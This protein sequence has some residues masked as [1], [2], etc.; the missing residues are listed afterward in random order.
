MK[1]L[2]IL[3]CSQR[4]RSEPGLLPAIERY[5]GP[6]FGVARKFLHE[7]PDGALSIYILS[8]QFGLI[9]AE[10][11]IPNYN[12]KMTSKRAGELHFQVLEKFNDALQNNA[13]SKLFIALGKNYWRA[14]AGYERLLPINLELT[15]A[16]GSPGR[17]QAELLIWLHNGQ[18]QQDEQPQARRGKVRLRGIALEFTPAEVLRIARQK[19]VEDGTQATSYQAWYVSVD[20]VRVA[21]KW[22]ASQLSGLPMGAFHTGDARRVLRQLGVEVRRL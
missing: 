10:M 18:L 2:L 4:K 20:D 13:P 7:Q 22:L 14:L 1:R 6:L 12:R 15:I 16:T 9:S 5:D 19:L 17:R 8:A 11:E 3:S 21:P